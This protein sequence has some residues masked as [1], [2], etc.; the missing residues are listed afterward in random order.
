[1]PKINWEKFYFG[2]EDFLEYDPEEDAMG[3]I[4]WNAEAFEAL[5]REQEEREQDARAP[6]TSITIT[7]GPDAHDEAREVLYHYESYWVQ[8]LDIRGHRIEGHV[9][10]RDGGLHIFKTT[11][12]FEMMEPPYTFVPWPDIEVVHVY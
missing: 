2:H 7:Y 12:A 11:K 6:D 4:D 3:T 8:V 10:Y 5:V 9:R 1:M